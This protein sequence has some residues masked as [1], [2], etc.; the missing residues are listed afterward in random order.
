MKKKPKIIKVTLCCPGDIQREVVIAREVIAGWNQQNEESTGNRI[1][2]FH[3]STDCAPTMEERGQAAINRK[4]IDDSDIIIA[5]F[6]TR[7]GTPTGLAGSGTEEEITRAM[8]RDIR[9]MPYFSKLESPYTVPDP[10]QLLKLEAFR[11]KMRDTGL[12]WTFNSRQD[13]RKM[14]ANHLDIAV[15]EV[16][17]KRQKSKKPAKKKG[18]SQ[19]SEGDGNIQS[20]GDNNVFN[21]NTQKK[22]S[23]SIERNLDHISP[24]EQKMVADWI[25]ELA[26]AST[27]DEIGK[28]IAGWWSRLRNHFKIPRYDLLH[29]NQMPLVKA[30][31]TQQLAMLKQGLRV[32]DPELWKNNTIGSIKGMMRKMGKEDDK[33]AYYLAIS[34][35]LN[36]KRPFKSLTKLSKTDLKRVY[37]VVSRDFKK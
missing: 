32:V 13:F 24:A 27:G 6:W 30:W 37:G 9:V 1:E 17:G 19:K 4:L 18:I 16:A 10:K 3:W 7:L 5:V 2:I 29:K 26:E 23:I 28:L 12:P 25:R 11:T 22:P 20:A 15:R 14:L 36:M 34:N 33:E 8:A 21:I 31:F 35:R